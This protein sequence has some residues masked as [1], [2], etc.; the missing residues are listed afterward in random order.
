MLA[1]FVITVDF[2]VLVVDDV[3]VVPTFLVRV[4]SLRERVVA[5]IVVLVAWCVSVHAGTVV[6]MVLSDADIVLSCDH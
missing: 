5:G 4:W 2:I 1:A 3:P 6:V